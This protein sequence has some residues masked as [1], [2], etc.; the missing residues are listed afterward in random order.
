MDLNIQ[1]TNNIP[2]TLTSSNIYFNYISDILILRVF[3]PGMPTMPIVKCKFLDVFRNNTVFVENTFPLYNSSLLLCFL[4]ILLY[5]SIL[6]ANLMQTESVFNN[7]LFR[8]I[9]CDNNNNRL[10]TDLWD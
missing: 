4:F 3:Q 1:K 10:L 8:K 6:E 9:K 7:T 2:F 5:F